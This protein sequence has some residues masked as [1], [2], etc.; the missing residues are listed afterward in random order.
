M[1]I[2]PGGAGSS[3]SCL[4][5]VSESRMHPPQ[6]FVGGQGGDDGP[7]LGAPLGP[8]ER[9]AERLQVAAHRLQLADEVLAVEPAR[10][11]LGEALERRTRFLRR[12]SPAA[13]RGSSAPS[14][15]PRSGRARR[16]GP[17]RAP[18]CRRCAPPAPRRAGPRSRRSQGGGSAAGRGGRRAGAR[19]APP[20]RRG[21]PPRGSRPRAGRPRSRPDPSASRASS[22]PRRAGGRGGRTRAARSRARGPA[23]AA[24]RCSAGGRS[25]ERRG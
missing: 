15:A 22:R 19:P 18:V 3:T 6:R 1:P 21:R 16:G 8:G 10:A 23:P 9:E 14:R 5:R 24:A 20:D 4:V 12:A 17:G 13:G 11:Q 2:G 7:Q 25:R